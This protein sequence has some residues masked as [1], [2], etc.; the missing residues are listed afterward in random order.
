MKIFNLFIA[1]VISLAVIACGDSKDKT[2]SDNKTNDNSNVE[3]T[4]NTT[5]NNTNTTT[6]QSGDG[7]KLSPVGTIEAASTK[8]TAPNFTWEENGQQMSMNDLKGKVVFVNL[9]ATW[10]GPCIKEMPELSAIST[11]LKDKDF[12]MVGLN[13]FHQEGTPDVKDFL[14]EKPVSYWVVDGN[15][16]LVAAFEQSTGAAIEGVPT[17]YII[18]KEGKIVETLVGMRSKEQ[19]MAEINKYL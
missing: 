18:D 10:C 6:E 8:G 11:E 1:L 17:T 9:W 5:P 3:N 4:S 2:T 13:V 15:D 16:E 12:K 7:Q 19:F 14:K